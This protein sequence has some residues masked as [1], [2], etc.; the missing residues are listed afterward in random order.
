MKAYKFRTAQN[1]DFVADIINK[2]LYCSDARALNDLR[3]G[4]IRVGDDR[5]RQIEAFDFGCRVSEALG[6]HRVGIIH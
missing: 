1:F 3:E 2:R 6:C 4:D 5:G